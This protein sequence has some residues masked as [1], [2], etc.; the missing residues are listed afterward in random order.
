MSNVTL[1]VSYYKY[2]KKYILREKT[3]FLLKSMKMKKIIAEKSWE[4]QK[5]N[6]NLRSKLHFQYSYMIFNIILKFKDQTK[7]LTTN[8]SH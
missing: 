4:I 7:G 8:L 6:N 1:C 2:N 5:N 3:S